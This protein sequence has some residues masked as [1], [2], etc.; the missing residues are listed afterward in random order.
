MDSNFRQNGELGRIQIGEKEKD[1]ERKE[2]EDFHF[3]V[4]H[5]TD[6]QKRGEKNWCSFVRYNV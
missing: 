6:P 4:P 3:A 2:K 5:F 1:G